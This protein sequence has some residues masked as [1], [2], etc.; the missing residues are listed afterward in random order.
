M[1]NCECYSS[2]YVYSDVELYRNHG[3]DVHIV[4]DCPR[5]GD[6]DVYSQSYLFE[7]VLDFVS[8]LAELY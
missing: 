8:K 1:Y 4:D 2:G 7:I 5:E 3:R 6:G